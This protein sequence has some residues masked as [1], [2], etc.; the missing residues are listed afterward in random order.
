MRVLE[1]RAFFRGALEPLA[2]GIEEGRIARIAK[3]LA[4][5]ERT[6][7]GDRLILPGAVDLHVHFR[8]PGATHKE[9]FGSGTAAAAIGGVTTVLDMPNTAPAVTTPRLY[10]EKLAAVGAKAHV[11]FGLYGAVRTPADVRAFAGLAPAGKVYLA[12]TT[13]FPD[14]VERD[15]VQDVVSALAA[16]GFPATVHAEAP[17]AFGGRARNLVAYDGARPAEAE[18]A[19]IRV[20]GDAARS[21][22]ATARIHVAHISS[23]AAVRAL[24]DTPFT[25]EA[26]PHHLFLDREKPLA[27]RGKVNPPLRSAA[28]RTELWKAFVDGRIT[29]I[30]SDHAPHTI[31]EKDLP[32]EEAP[33]GLPGVETML[34]LLL[35]AVRRGELS[36]ERLV[37]AAATRPAG[38]LRLE[39]GAIEVGHVANLMVVDPRALSVIRA[40]DLHSKCGWTPFE[41]FEGIFPEATY[42]HGELAAEARELVGEHHGRAIP[43]RAPGPSV[44][45]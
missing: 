45:S 9:D 1:G 27:G 11:D 20:L 23:M 41:G 32:F 38:L 29:T 8:D 40:K 6:D 14:P 44:A 15:A 31:E 7:Y 4:G 17:W 2:V 37:D 18:A 35:R 26:T 34:P 43:V 19:A 22:T 25:S 33:A 24:E 10:R 12:P 5:E 13:G 42:V 3:T 28:E 21:A 36:L 39:V 30:A 16:A